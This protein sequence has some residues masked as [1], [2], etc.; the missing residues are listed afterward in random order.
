MTIAKFLNAIGPDKITGDL[1]KAQIQSFTGPMMMTAGPMGCGKVSPVFQS[2]CGAEMGI[3]QY[4]NGKWVPI[5]DALNGKAINPG[6]VLA[7]S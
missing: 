2:L 7:K 3:E 4:L 5:A 1:V 6:E